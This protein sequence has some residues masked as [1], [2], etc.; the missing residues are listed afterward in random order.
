MTDRA[1]LT[2]VFGFTCRKRPK[3]CNHH[4]PRSRDGENSDL[5]VAFGY[6]SAERAGNLPRKLTRGTLVVTHPR[7]AFRARVV[8]IPSLCYALIFL[9]RWFVVLGA[10]G[11]RHQV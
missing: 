10:K 11:K 9:T 6:V 4:V 2:R 7:T 5:Y 3:T 8:I 1:V